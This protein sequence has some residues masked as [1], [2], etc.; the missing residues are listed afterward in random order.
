MS[1]RPQHSVEN[2]EIRR[3]LSA[4][5]SGG[6]ATTDSPTDAPHEAD[7]TGAAFGREPI[8]PPLAPANWMEEGV[9]SFE[10]PETIAATL[11]SGTAAMEDAPPAPPPAR[12]PLGEQSI[13]VRPSPITPTA[14]P[15]E[16]PAS[17]AQQIFSEGLPLGEPD[18]LLS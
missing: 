2:L 12:N 4:N 3:L 6:P 17:I 18:D 5:G 13:D 10:L 1:P 14:V 9:G 16:R 7:S 15:P 11:F 8:Y